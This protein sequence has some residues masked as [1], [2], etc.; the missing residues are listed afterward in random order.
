M[1]YG[2]P[3]ELETTEVEGLCS[4]N[5][6]KHRAGALLG[7]GWGLEGC[8]EGLKVAPHRGAAA[9]KE[10]HSLETSRRRGPPCKFPPNFGH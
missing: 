1:V 4:G 5:S 10:T 7:V 9:S 8:I 3:V 2:L 6:R